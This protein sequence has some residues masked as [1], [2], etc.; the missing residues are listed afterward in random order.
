MDSK[1]RISIPSDLRRSLGFEEGDV[2]SVRIDLEK[3]MLVIG[4][5]GVKASTAG[6]GPAGPG[7]IPGSGPQKLKEECTK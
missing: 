3:G 4:Q 1:G 6:C 2:L 5:S 7:S